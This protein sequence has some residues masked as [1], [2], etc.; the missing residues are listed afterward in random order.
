MKFNYY[1]LTLY[2]KA[3]SK[4]AD[5]GYVVPNISGQLNIVAENDPAYQ[6]LDG[7]RSP[8]CILYKGV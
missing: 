7:H 1:F 6:D 3:S 8:V 4:Q 5:P 2:R